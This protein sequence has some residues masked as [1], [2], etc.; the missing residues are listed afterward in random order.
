MYRMADFVNIS[1]AANA[2]IHF[3]YCNMDLNT[4]VLYN[5]A[6]ILPLSENYAYNCLK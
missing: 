2:Q 5:N 1:Q 4:L 3:A 6:M